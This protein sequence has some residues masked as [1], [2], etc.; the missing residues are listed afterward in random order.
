MCTCLALPLTEL[1]GP[2]CAQVVLEIKEVRPGTTEV[3]LKH[4]GIP[5]TDRHGNEDVLET[6]RT[7]WKQQIFQKI[8]AVFGFGV[9]L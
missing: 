3:R 2:C 4:T 8:R 7:G 6:T 9:G 5:E 1:I